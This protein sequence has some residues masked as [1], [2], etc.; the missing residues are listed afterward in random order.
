MQLRSLVIIT[1]LSGSGKHTVFKAFED[2]GYFCVDNIPIPLIPRLIQLSGATA[3]R[4]D[5]L[6]LVVDARLGEA[7]QDLKNMVKDLR[8][9]PTRTVLMFVEASEEA[10][11]RRYSETRRVHPLA[12]DRDVLEG[13]REEQRKLRDIR[14]LADVVLNTSD[15]TVHELRRFV[16]ENFR[17]VE[18]TDSLVITVMSFGYKNGIPFNADLVFDVRFLPNP[19]F[20]AGLKE[21]TGSDPEVVQYM[22]QFADTDTVLEKIADLLRYLIPKYIQE[23][24]SYLTI[25]VGCTGGR[26][27]SV[28]V[29]DALRQRLQ[30]TGLK[31]NVVHRDIHMQEA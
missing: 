19:N 8:H 16:E 1:G 11:A 20:E 14:S 7:I 17:D 21:K 30:E 28:M 26:H 6:A 5:K 18:A 22:K 31:I 15:Y 3:G 10:L 2:L 25:G 13:I 4:I 29:A 24:K 23:G 27:R 9:Y 12:P